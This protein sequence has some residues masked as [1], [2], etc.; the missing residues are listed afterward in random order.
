MEVVC[1]GTWSYAAV[2]HS[3]WFG[4]SVAAEKPASMTAFRRYLPLKRRP[5]GMTARRA[6]EAG[7]LV[8]QT[9]LAT[10]LPR[11]KK[12]THLPVRDPATP[13]P[14]TPCCTAIA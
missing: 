3:K 9:R 7:R 8:C 10:F 11:S 5:T 13:A 6:G 2:G 14:R 12:V 4:R 1:G